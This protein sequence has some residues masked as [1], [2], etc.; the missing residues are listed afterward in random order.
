MLKIFILSQLKAKNNSKLKSFKIFT[1]VNSKL[2]ST[3]GGIV[4]PYLQDNV[5]TLVSAQLYH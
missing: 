4:W 1:Y 5:F 2:K 3:T